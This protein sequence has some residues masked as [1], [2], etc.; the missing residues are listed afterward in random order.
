M[1][2]GWAVYTERMMLEEGY[3]NNSPELWLMYY[4]WNLR[5]VCNTIL[6][7][8]I[9]VNGM[10]EDQAMNLMVNEAFQ[11]MAEAKGKWRRATLSQVQL[12]SYFTGFHEIMELRSELKDQQ[13]ADFDL[14]GFHEEFLSFGSAPVKYVR[15]LMMQSENSLATSNSGK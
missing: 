1:V 15:E 4:K 5:T 6:D 12:C 14:K 10:T 13:Q 8:S 11:Q 7:Y 3:G 9:H 2:E